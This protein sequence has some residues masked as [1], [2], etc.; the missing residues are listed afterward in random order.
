MTANDSVEWQCRSGL[1]EPRVGA[2]RSPQHR[3]GTCAR[4]SDTQ[5]CN[6]FYPLPI[7]FLGTLIH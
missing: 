3:R 2:P 6:T 5:E 7:T 1:L 4:D